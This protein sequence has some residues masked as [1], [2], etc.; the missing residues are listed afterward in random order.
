MDSLTH[1]AL[2]ACV[3]ELMAGRKLG[4]KAM[5]WGAAAQSLPDIDFI[6]GIWTT[7]AEELLAH[8]GFTHSFLFVALLTPFLA[9]LAS[10]W[11]QARGISLKNWLWFFGLQQLIHILIDALN[12]Y[13]TGWFEPFSHVRVAC[14][15][16]FVADPFF[17][18]SLIVASVV[19]LLRRKSRFRR[20]W[21]IGGILVSSVYL[22][23]AGFSKMVVENT[24]A[25][26]LAQQH[27]Q[28]TTHFTT[29][30]PFNTWLWYAVAKSDSG[31]YI[32]YRSV[33]D[34][35]PQITFQYVPRQDSLLQAISSQEDLQHLIRF[36]KG[37]YSAQ[38]LGDTLVFNDLRFG[39]IMGWANPRAR[40]VFYY[41][42]KHPSANTMLVQRG[43]M[44]GW[45]AQAWLGL[46]RRIKG[47]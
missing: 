8:R 27:I 46:A 9:L 2:G 13:G 26:S 5:L 15:T 40:F 32:G 37:Y 6:A 21:A 34:R 10:R 29:P 33:F 42:L 31:Y 47:D 4:R 28:Y 25:R 45:N 24:V 3:G 11:H 23:Q 39:Q 41:Y 17:T 19:L 1:I 22:V 12:A 18:F 16:L 44:A 35:S 38:Q 20:Q 7:P 36:S 43:R 14:D 30:T